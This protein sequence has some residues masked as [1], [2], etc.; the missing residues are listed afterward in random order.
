MLLLYPALLSPIVD[1]GYG[2]ISVFL[3]VL[4]SLSLS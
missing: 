4:A 3:V 1:Y 2:A